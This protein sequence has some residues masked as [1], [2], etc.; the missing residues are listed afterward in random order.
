MAG[1]AIPVGA[2]EDENKGRV[3]TSNSTH[4]HTWR[5]YSAFPFELLLRRL[6][7]LAGCGRGSFQ[8]PSPRAHWS[9]CPEQVVRSP[10]E[11]VLLLLPVCSFCASE[12]NCNE[13]SGCMTSGLSGGT[14]DK[15]PGPLRD[16]SVPRA[17]RC[18]CSTCTSSNLLL[19]LLRVGIRRL[20][21]YSGDGVLFCGTDDVPA[22]QKNFFRLLLCHDD[23]NPR[24]NAIREEEAVQACGRDHEISL[25]TRSEDYLVL[26]RIGYKLLPGPRHT[27]TSFQESK[28]NS[29]ASSQLPQLLRFMAELPGA[30]KKSPALLLFLQPSRWLS[31]GGLPA[32]TGA[33]ALQSLSNRKSY[34]LFLA[35]LLK[36]AASCDKNPFSAVE[37]IHTSNKG[38]P[39]NAQTSGAEGQ[40]HSIPCYAVVGECF[41]CCPNCCWRCSRHLAVVPSSRV[42]LCCLEQ[43]EW[44]GMLRSRFSQVF[45]LFVGAYCPPS[46]EEKAADT[47]FASSARLAADGGP[48][49]FVADVTNVASQV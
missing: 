13:T 1:Q 46:A 31:A 24:S 34:G 42:S 28:C 33:P 44:L 39:G 16:A 14:C 10:S 21:E 43:S 17:S 35:L 20:K 26:T 5:G 8:G 11:T 4:C 47:T 48:V 18:V 27:T 37:V 3:A 6:V 2:L 12:R 25:S 36:A 45:L 40:Q 29:P 19:A 23:Q 15:V 22:R 9:C 32:C 38:F 7:G 30:L 41:L 49:V